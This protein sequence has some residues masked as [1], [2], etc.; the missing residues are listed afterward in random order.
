MGTGGTAGSDRGRDS[1]AGEP[2]P[3]LS[4]ELGNRIWDTAPPPPPSGVLTLNNSFIHQK[5]THRGC[6]WCWGFQ[7]EQTQVTDLTVGIKTRVLSERTHIGCCSQEGFTE[8]VTLDWS[9]EGQKGACV[10]EQA[11]QSQRQVQRA[12]EA[13][14]DA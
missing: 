10:K 6:A 7:G 5:R 4:V 11:K 13:G 1:E 3:S 8:E 12:K 9:P 14:H 2:V